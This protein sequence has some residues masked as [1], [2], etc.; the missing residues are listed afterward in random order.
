MSSALNGRGKTN[1][2][3]ILLLIIFLKWTKFRFMVIYAIHVQV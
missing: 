3:N 2:R 1:V